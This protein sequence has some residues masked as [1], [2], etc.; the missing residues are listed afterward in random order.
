MKLMTFKTLSYTY[1][2]FRIKGRRKT[3]ISNDIV[4]KREFSGVLVA[5]NGKGLGSLPYD[6]MEPFSIMFQGRSRERD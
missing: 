2:E 6:V 3:Q 5:D 4:S 1:G